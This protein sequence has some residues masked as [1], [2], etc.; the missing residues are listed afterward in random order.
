MEHLLLPRDVADHGPSLVPYACRE[1]Y[2][3]GPF[4]TYP[5]RLGP[6]NTFALETQL[7]YDIIGRV[8]QAS[9]AELESFVQ[10]WIFFGLLTEV[11]GDFFVPSQYVTAASAVDLDESHEQVLNTRELVPAVKK[12][13]QQV[14][15]SAD[16]KEEKR[17]QYEHIATCLQLAFTTLNAVRTDIRSDFSPWIRS[18]I[19]SVGELLTRATNVVY[20]IED[21]LRDN[22]CPGTWSIPYDDPLHVKQMLSEGY[23]PYEIHRIR[24]LSLNVQTYH[25]LLWMDRSVPSTQHQTCSDKVCQANQI[26]VPSYITKHRQEGC[27]CS[28]F[29]IDVQEVIRILSGGHL[30]LLRITNGSHLSDVHVDVIEATPTAKYVAISH[31][32]ADGLGNPKSNSLPQCQLQHLHQITSKFFETHKNEHS[33]EG[34]FIWIDTLCCPV[35]PLEAKLMALNQIRTPYTN[36]SH[37]LVLHSSIQCVNVLGLTPA[38]VCLRIFTSGWMRRLWTLQEGALPRNLWFQFKDLAVDLDLVFDEAFKTYSTEIGRSTLLE[39]ITM[40]YRGLRHFFHADGNVPVASLA[41]LDDA[42]GFRSVSVA[43]DE[44]IL[45][46]GLL[47]LDLAYILGGTEESRMQR[48]WSLVASSPTGVP[49]NILFHRGS[50]LRQRGYRWAPASLLSINRDLDGSLASREAHSTGYLSPFGLKVH[51]SAFAT[52]NMVSAPPGAPRNPWGL[53]ND[54]DENSIRCRG[55][56]G[57]WL[58]MAGKYSGPHKEKDL[59]GNSLY[60]ILKHAGG[61]QRLL[62]ASA[63]KFDGSREYTSALLVHDRA[64]I[65]STDPSQ[66]ISDIIVGVGKVENVYQILFE[67]AFQASRSLL[68]DEITA[69]YAHLAIEDE[70]QQKNN[71]A[72]GDLEKQLEQ[73]ILAL[74]A[75]VVN[76]S[77]QNEMDIQNNYKLKRLIPALI[78]SAYLGEYCSLGPILPTETKW[79]V[80]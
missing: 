55:D 71:P 28:D 52:A 67:A 56:Q 68:S 65:D 1:E 20:A 43:S 32:F 50:R 4:L 73:K 58:Y 41:I 42:L 75:S 22:K 44:A 57:T 24:N 80:D 16:T 33:T 19:A 40:L 66:V 30:P 8:P 34:M 12:W 62:L 72:Y 76:E 13:M 31:V 63:F 23:C 9:C 39:D 25:L 60:A 15:K 36:A 7:D 46:G 29:L 51:A 78:A 54:R 47:N 59:T 21:Y 5:T 64:D 61:P 37:V 10:T 53:Y 70:E 6:S 27:K 38:E 18:S 14:Q 77:L 49:R 48:V 26:D 17:S 45:I 11:L 3:G 2:D 79:C 74:A 35:K 69:Q